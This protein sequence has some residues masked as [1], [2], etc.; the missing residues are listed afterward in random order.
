MATGVI[1]GTWG[2]P[3]I[4]SE[5]MGASEVLGSDDLWCKRRLVIFDRIEVG[6]RRRAPYNL[7]LPHG[8]HYFDARFISSFSS[9]ISDW[10]GMVSLV[11]DDDPKAH[12]SRVGRTHDVS[13]FSQ[14]HKS[15]QVQNIAALRHHRVPQSLTRCLVPPDDVG[16]TVANGD[17]TRERCVR[18]ATRA[19]QSSPSSEGGVSRFLREV[20][21]RIELC[22]V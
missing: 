12:S 19:E 20:S 5:S 18:E 11:G 3:Y 14:G 4:C 2:G 8:L 6:G 22:S 7:S 16:T 17:V 9:N 1:G 15:R 13:D 21:F 10:R